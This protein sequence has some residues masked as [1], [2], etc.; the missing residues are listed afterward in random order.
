MSLSIYN[1]NI[2]YR[3]PAEY[4]RTEVYVA[5]TIQLIQH[6]RQVKE[7]IRKLGSPPVWYVH[8]IFQLNE[9]ITPGVQK[10]LNFPLTQFFCL[11]FPL[12]LAHINIILC[13]RLIIHW[14]LRTNVRICQLTNILCLI[15]PIGNSGIHST[16][17]YWKQFYL[18][19]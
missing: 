2:I 14:W 19:K 3:I 13:I 7:L 5:E 12:N 18:L 1:L 8:W 10:I 16:Y 11:K 9:W 15:K 6:S 17:T 4:S